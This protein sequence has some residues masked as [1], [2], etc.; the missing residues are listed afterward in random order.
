[1][2]GKANFLGHPIHP[3]L[4]ALPLGLLPAA[5][6]CDIVYL[7][8]HRG[9]WG[10]MA[11]WLIAGGIVGGVLAGI[12]GFIDWL[13]IPARTRAKRIG[14]LHAVLNLVVLGVF[15]VSWV[16]RREDPAAP[17][18]TAALLGALALVVSFV[19][20]WLGGELI[21]RLSIGVDR[22]A[23]PDAAS[24]LK[25]DTGRPAGGQI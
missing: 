13:S 24:S 12:F 21:Y 14:L 17:P 1:M 15:A 10:E 20:A 6:V 23:H 2:K 8:T 16:M 3:M 5:V 19:S 11:Y 25:K 18:F 22:E 9:F 4:V 7:V